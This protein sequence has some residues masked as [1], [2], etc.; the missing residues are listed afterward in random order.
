METEVFFIVIQFTPPALKIPPN[1]ALRKF[2]SD[3]HQTYY[4][5]HKIY[6]HILARFD[7]QLY[8]STFYRAKIIHKHWLNDT[9]CLLCNAL[10]G[11]RK[12]FNNAVFCVVC[13]VTSPQ[14]EVQS[15]VISMYV[16]LL[17]VYPLAC[18]RNHVSKFHEILCTCYPWLWL[19]SS[20]TTM[21]NVM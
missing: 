8:C 14:V 15:I 12:S 2:L 6:D 7:Y 19:G 17:S 20:L 5:C 3:L 10:I 13:L 4:H 18:L 11:S 21:Q 1:L 16:C 9:S